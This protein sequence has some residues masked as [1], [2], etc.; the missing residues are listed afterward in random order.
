MLIKWLR[1]V[2]LD[3]KKPQMPETTVPNNLEQL[4]AANLSVAIKCIKAMY[5][6]V[7]VHTFY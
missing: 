7:S 6:D 5:I 1:E 4:T 2:T 3:G